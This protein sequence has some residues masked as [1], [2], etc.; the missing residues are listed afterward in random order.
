[1]IWRKPYHNLALRRQSAITA[2]GIPDGDSGMDWHA[3]R[4][5]TLQKSQDRFDGSRKRNAEAMRSRP[6]SVI[7]VRTIQAVFAR[8]P[9]KSPR[10]L[11]LPDWGAPKRNGRL[12][13]PPE[14]WRKSHSAQSGSGESNHP[15]S[16]CIVDALHICWAYFGTAR[17][18]RGRK[19]AVLVAKRV[20]GMAN[21]AGGPKSSGEIPD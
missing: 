4:G 17:W 2:N 5:S 6:G 20:S 3:A 11:R 14:F 13:T 7:G 10:S 15:S 18:A 21:V 8:G 9:R 12:H 19:R 1:M 16:T